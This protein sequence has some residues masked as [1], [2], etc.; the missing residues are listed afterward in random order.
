M[1][2]V[3][4]CCESKCGGARLHTPY[5]NVSAVQG[6]EGNSAVSCQPKVARVWIQALSEEKI[7]KRE[8]EVANWILNDSR[9]CGRR[10]GKMHT[11]MLQPQVN[12]IGH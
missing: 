8:A 4:R 6:Q 7:E 1:E 10:I 11:R 3:N 2:G 9:S 5:S 12:S